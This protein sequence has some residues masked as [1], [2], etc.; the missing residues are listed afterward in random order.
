MVAFDGVVRLR[1]LP[2]KGGCDLPYWEL[3]LSVRVLSLGWLSP[4]V[5][6][7]NCTWSSVSDGVASLPAPSPPPHSSCT[8]LPPT[9]RRQ[10]GYRL[11]CVVSIF[12]LIIPVFLTLWPPSSRSRDPCRHTPFPPHPRP[13]SKDIRTTN[14][15]IS[16]QQTQPPHQ[17]QLQQPYA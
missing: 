15:P 1:I 12:P 11:E 5:P 6:P 3:F 4:P 13:A 16:P 10:Q 9:P 17:Q 8:S 7:P 2:D 14:Q